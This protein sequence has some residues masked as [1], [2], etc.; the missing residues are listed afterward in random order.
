MNCETILRKEFIELIKK[1][2]VYIDNTN[3]IVYL[4]DNDYFDDD[5]YLNCEWL[6]AVD[7]VLKLVDELDYK[8]MT[9][10]NGARVYLA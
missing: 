2:G 6:K 8:I 10:I 4:L 5:L 3:Q 1:D 7:E 9:E